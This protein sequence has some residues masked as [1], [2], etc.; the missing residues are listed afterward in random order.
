MKKSEKYLDLI[1]ESVAESKAEEKR[2]ANEDAKIQ[3]AS[4]IL[5][6][7]KAI[8]DAKRS[9]IVSQKAEPYNLQNE[10]NATIAVSD[11]EETLSLAKKIVALRF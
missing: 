2:F 6:T 11:L 5:A 10:I 4:S 8:S 9:L 1:S 7:E 3:V